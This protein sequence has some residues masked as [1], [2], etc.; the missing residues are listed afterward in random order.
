MTDPRSWTIRLVYNDLP[1]SLNDRSHYMVVWRDRQ[2][3]IG[4]VHLACR[5]QRI[6]R[7]ERIG[8][9]MEWTPRLNRRRD[10]DNAVATLKGCLDGL[11][12]APPSKRWPAGRVGVIPDD[13]PEHVTWSPPVI[14]PAN[15]DP[16]LTER[17][18][19]VIQ[20]VTP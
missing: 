5:A 14:H 15:P 8:V 10:S 1:L 7:M 11:R 9:R 4:R 17:L 16:W 18:T 3:L 6:P 20:E 12:D 19:L 2:N 13:T